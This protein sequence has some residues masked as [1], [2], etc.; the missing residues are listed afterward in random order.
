MPKPEEQTSG[1]RLAVAAQP[2]PRQMDVNIHTSASASDD[3][4]DF[5]VP[6]AS[7]GGRTRKRPLSEFSDDSDEDIP[8]AA[9]PNRPKS[10]RLSSNSNG[11][12]GTERKKAKDE[13]VMEDDTGGTDLQ[14]AT[15]AATKEEDVMDD[16]GDNADEEDDVQVKSEDMKE[17]SDSDAPLT[18]RLKKKT[19]VKG[20][21]KTNGASKT[22]SG[23]GSSSPRSAK[24]K[25]LAKKLQQAKANEASAKEA[26]NA[27]SAGSASTPSGNPP[28]GP[29]ANGDGN[30]TY[31]WWDQEG[32]KEGAKWSTLE[33]CAVLFPPAY[34]PHG[35]KLVYDGKKIELQPQ[36]EEVATFYA[37]KLKTDY[38]E[39]ETFN[40]NFFKD[41]R[42]SMVGSPAYKVVK[43]LK[44]CDF[45]PI[46]ELLERRKE[47]KKSRPL[48]LRK[49]EKEEENKRNEKYTFAMVDGRKEKVGN[50]RIEPPGLFLG[51]GEH[52][53]MGKVKKRIDPEDVT[54]NIGEE[55]TLPPCPIEG[56]KWGEIV[57]K[58][59]VTWLC[60]WKD[61][62]TGGHKYVWLAAGSTFKGMSDHS[63]FEKAR[64]LD[65][66][67]AQVRKDYRQGWKSKSKEVR[68]R[69]VAM[70]LIDKLALRAG[71]EKG[72]DEADTVGCCSLRVEHLTFLEDLWI[73]FDFL[74][75]DSMRYFNKVQV[76]KQVYENLK[77]FCRNKQGKEPIFHRLTVPGLNNYLKSIMAGLTAKVFRT[78]NASITL[79]NLLQDTPVGSDLNAKI[80]FYNQQNKEVA[81]LCNHQ[82]SLPKTHGAQME[83]FDTRIDELT[84]WIRELKRGRK[85]L[86]DDPNL[87]VVTVTQYVPVKPE[88]TEE[89]NDEQRREEKKRVATLDKVPEEKEKKLPQIE[90]LIS[91]CNQ[92]LAKMEADRQVKE[93]LKTVSLGTSK[94]NYLDPRI[95]VAWCKKHDVPI[96]KI[97]PK[98]L[99]V[100]FAWAMEAS[101]KFRFKP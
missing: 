90:N 16:V 56:R 88:Y 78:Y 27:A 7:R 98:T 37:A 65:A 17:D 15:S 100:K 81:I 50:F 32:D 59:N 39:K 46:W 23:A 19:P 54:I 29:N 10:R 34:E 21:K 67:I 85:K 92:R 99:L 52:P 60:G 9:T 75:K 47:E 55:A 44:K 18:S 77:L 51:R 3:D 91:T 14:H 73:E 53:L 74:G 5:D 62:I 25:N 35:V 12:N 69:S 87:S 94:I 58:H 8:L 42:Y 79:D 38:I 33:H 93:D 24:T 82:R 11:G 48:A 95:T 36:A 40:V 89:M 61:S 57:H 31:R 30:D 86:K 97:F 1:D 22:A 2:L 70:Y 4:D 20:K 68:Q 63:K 66:H 96:E 26:A 28:S 49:K 45:L 72:E 13:D 43:D 6:L 84:A 76:E 80:V 41:F 83:K 101:E 64:E 71:G